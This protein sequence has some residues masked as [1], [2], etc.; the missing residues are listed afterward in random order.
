M[1]KEYQGGGCLIEML[2][3]LTRMNLLRSRRPLTKLRSG[4]ESMIVRFL[5]PMKCISIAEI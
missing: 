5:F 3:R 4:V 1:E 2:F